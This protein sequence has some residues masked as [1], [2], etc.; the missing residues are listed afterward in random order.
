MSKL[1]DN[2]RQA[3]RMRHYSI[4]TERSYVDWIKRYIYF[5]NLRHPQDMGVLEIRAFLSDLAVRHSVA[6]STQNQAFA[7]LLFLYKNVLQIDLPYI[8][9][10]ERAKRPQRLPV[11]FT[12]SE[13][14]E[15]L[16]RMN[17]NA[18][19]VA[20][21]LYGAGLRVTEAVSLRVKDLDFDSCQIFVRDGKGSKD[22][23]TMLPSSIAANLKTHLIRVKKQHEDDL[24]LGFGSVYLPYA[25]ARKYP[26]AAREWIWQ[27]VFP[28]KSL[29]IDP[30]SGEKR[31]HHLSEDSINR[32]VKIALQNSNISKNGS[33]HTFR[34]S[35]ATHLLE[36]GYD[37]RTVQELLGHKELSTTMIYTHVLNKGASAVKSPL[38]SK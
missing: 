8:E 15:I 12:Q 23:K 1:L 20:G 16:L 25:L 4:R 14:R 36:N 38:D 5:H 11:V 35:F 22:R 34:H 9:G 2:V 24:R 29:S 26:N 27:Y 31:R 3:I 17:G 13:A 28:A 30:R 18:Y 7:A 33:A 10:V 32:A 37:I 21:L 19:L 6:A